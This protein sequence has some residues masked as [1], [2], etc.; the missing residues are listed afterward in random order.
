[1]NPVYQSGI[2]VHAECW[3]S[4]QFWEL[5]HLS[6]ILF[7]LTTPLSGVRSAVIRGREDVTQLT[8]RELDYAGVAGVGAAWGGD[9][10]TAPPVPRFAG[11]PAPVLAH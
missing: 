7:C 3:K 10:A 11:R 2:V 9:A 1:M 4:L 5:S 6:R 8:M